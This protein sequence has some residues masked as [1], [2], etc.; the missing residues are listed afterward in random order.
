M[1]LLALGGGPGR[2][3]AVEPP[4][5]PLTAAQKERLKNRDR[6]ASE[7]RKAEAT[8]KLA[9][10]IPAVEKILTIE[11]EVFGSVHAE[12][13]GSLDWLARLRA[14]QGDFVAARKAAQEAWA[15]RTKLYGEKHWRT[16]DARL[17]L[18]DV[19]RLRQLTPA[20]R[21]A[22][23]EARIWMQK[24]WKLRRQRKYQEA[25]ALARKAAGVYRKHL[26]EHRE[27]AVALN[28]LGLNL[29]SG[30]NPSAAQPVYE[31][32]LA[33]RKKVLGENHPDTA[34]ILNNLGFVMEARKDYQAALTH[35]ERAL[36]VRECTLGA[37][38]P[39]TGA[40]MTHLARVCELLA[41]V[42]EDAGDFDA[43]RTMR[44]QVL[45]LRKRQHGKDNWRVRDAELRLADV[46][47]LARLR[48]EQRQ[49]LR[50]ARVLKARAAV[51]PAG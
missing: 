7:A 40:S 3:T 33:I 1:V 28:A 45:T 21:A 48:P 12:V 17:R 23:R 8:G 26:G 11:R 15:V 30:G 51:Q 16:T 50:E 32:A 10:A 13:A 41:G 44:R 9:E 43:A 4:R 39:D 18:A 29:D 20:A 27:T 22:L 2:A 25:A 5:P 46:D 24:V 49:R 35:H 34:T 47:V 36:A 38:H 6:F 19:E 37:N 14:E 42:Q 31:C